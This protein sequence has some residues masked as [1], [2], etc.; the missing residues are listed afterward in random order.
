MGS[1]TISGVK[2]SKVDVAG[3]GKNVSVEGKGKDLTVMIDGKEVK[4]NEDGTLLHDE[5][6]TQVSISPEGKR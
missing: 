3:G 2:N 6:G 1:I 5:G 4:L